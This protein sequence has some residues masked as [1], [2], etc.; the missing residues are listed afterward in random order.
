M[1][2]VY[3][4]KWC[5]H[6]HQT[7]DYLNDNNIEF[8]YIEMELQPKQVIDKIVEINGGEDWVVP[9]LEYNGEWREGKIYNEKE[10]Y[11]DLKRMGV[12]VPST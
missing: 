12:P 5:P 10:L 2:K 7:I 3:S 4:A 9:T 11:S 6:C 8:E 1:L